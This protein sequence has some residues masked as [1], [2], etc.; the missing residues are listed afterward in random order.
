ML[1]ALTTV[2]ALA[3]AVQAAPAP[4]SESVA[5]RATGSGR[6][7]VPALRQSSYVRNGTAAMLKAYRK[8][9]LTPTREM[10]ASFMSSLSKRQDGS[11]PA[12]PDTN[13]VEYLVPTTVG[14]QVLN[15][16]FDTGS[17]DLYVFIF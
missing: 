4:V 11:A 6:H 10:P 12:S 16:D 1:S 8:H 17:A 2:L 9:N 15:L 14:G 13:D 3:A 7:T 5:I